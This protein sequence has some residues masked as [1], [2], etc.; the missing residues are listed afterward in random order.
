MIDFDFWRATVLKFAVQ[1]HFSL[2]IK[3]LIEGDVVI[4]FNLHLGVAIGE[5]EG[6]FT[7]L[8][9]QMPFNHDIFVAKPCA[10]IE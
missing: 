2:R 9:Q 6:V 5:Y 7:H 4:Q 3:G 1:A 10:F 8:A